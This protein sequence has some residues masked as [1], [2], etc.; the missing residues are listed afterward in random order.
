MSKIKDSIIKRGWI[1]FHKKNQSNDDTGA[2]CPE[3]GYPSVKICTM[4]TYDKPHQGLYC[5]R[6]QIGVPDCKWEVNWLD[7]EKQ[8]VKKK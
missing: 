4:T 3:C 8:E 6:S 1:E 5:G 2:I 7:H